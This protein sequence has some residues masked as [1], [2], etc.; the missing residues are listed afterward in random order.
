MNLSATGALL[1]AL[2][3]CG[4]GAERREEAAVEPRAIC[5][6]IEGDVGAWSG[7]GELDHAR[8]P[9]CLGPVASKGV[10]RVKLATLGS[11]TY[12]PPSALGEVRIDWWMNGGRVVLVELTPAPPLAAAPLEATLGRVDASFRYG[13]EELAYWNLDAPPGGALEEQVYSARGLSL[14]VARDAR[15]VATAIRIRGFTP[16]AAERYLDDY[17]R[18]QPEPL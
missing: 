13:E 12:R 5:R 10:R 1:L 4:G 2:A 16:M 7:L 6:L 15:G 18:L 14:L 17:V 9:A 8:L 11:E 3:A